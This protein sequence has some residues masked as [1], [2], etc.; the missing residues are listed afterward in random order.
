MICARCDRFE[1][2][3]QLAPRAEAVELEATVVD[4]GENGTAGLACVCAVAETALGSERLDVLER[5][6]EVTLPELQLAQARRV[7]R[8]RAVGQLHELAMGRRV[9]ARAVVRDGGRA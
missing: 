6:A 3:L 2:A 9:P 1:L 5:G 7:D 4:R 8:Q